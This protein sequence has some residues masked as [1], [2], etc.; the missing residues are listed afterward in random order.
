MAYNCYSSKRTLHGDWEK[1][2]LLAAAEESV[3]RVQMDTSP[4]LP[5]PGEFYERCSDKSG[6]RAGNSV[7][8]ARE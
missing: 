5:S 6:K 2:T 4:Y 7:P 3:K 1:S 8:W